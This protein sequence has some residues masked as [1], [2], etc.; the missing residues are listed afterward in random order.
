MAKARRRG[1]ALGAAIYVSAAAGLGLSCE[2]LARSSTELEAPSARRDALDA[3][4][5][6][7]TGTGAHERH[8]KMAMTCQTCHACGGAYQ[9]SEL[10]LPGG[11][12]TA[13]GQVTR[14]PGGAS[15]VVGCH[16]PFGAPPQPV[17]WSSGPLSCSSCHHQGRP[18]PAPAQSGHAAAGAD[19]AADRAGCAACHVTDQHLSGVARV[20]VGEGQV[21]AVVHGDGA[22]LQKACEGC[23]DG[24]G[25]AVGGK[26]PPLLPSYASLTGDFHGARAGVGFGGTLKAPYARGQ[27]PLPCTVC[28]DTHA[29]AN[30]FLLAATV[31]GA[32]IAPASI[33]RQGVG[34]EKLC[35]ACHVG[36]RHQKCIDCHGADP[37]GPG[38]PCFF[39]HG[40][41]GITH[42]NLVFPVPAHRTYPCDHCHASWRP[43]LESAAPILTGSPG[44][45]VTHVTTQSATVSW[46]TDEPATSFVEYG[47]AE[48]GRVAGNDTFSLTHEV[49]LVGLTDATVYQYRVRSSD[50]LRNLLRTPLA[51][52]TTASAHGPGAP[53]PPHVNDAYSADTT[54]QVPLQWPAVPDPDGDPVQYRALVDDA[55][56]FATPV[57]DSGWIVATR[58]DAHLPSWQSA[59]FYWKVQARDAAHDLRSPWSATDT[60]V[61]V[62]SEE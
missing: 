53:L 23:H 26:T 37:M 50:K 46:T 8:G 16:H 29:S 20:V 54:V 21:A 44:V 43:I 55:P 38:N 3:G 59:R 41:E 22:T 48:L 10:T 27:A 56:D 2:Q 61:V 35:E 39:C 1:R 36:A 15:C 12:T 33:T 25:R 57:L 18:G 42:F 30:P 40:H 58:Y 24:D 17:S 34:A 9:L 49:T 5:A 7:C 62:W 13:G 4:L 6:A 11:T 32:A 51:T 60:F 52:F 28:H 47:A 31:N 19:I 14:G 45:Q